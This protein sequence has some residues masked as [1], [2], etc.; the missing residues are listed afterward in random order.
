V[1]TVVLAEDE[2]LLR[3]GLRM[4]LERDDGI[5]VVAEAADGEAALA[6]VA[7]HHPDVLLIDLR[8][9]GLGGI[10]AIRLLR[11]DTAMGSTRALVLT[12][13][14]DDT[15]VLDALR[16]GADGYLL[17]DLD[18][19]ELRRSVRAVAAGD[20]VVS[21]AV[22][23][24]VLR[25]IAGTRSPQSRLLDTFTTRETDV[26]AAVGRGLSNA[27]IAVELHLSPATVRTYVSR[28]LSR[29]GARDRAQLV[30]LAY[31]S[32]LMDRTGT[33]NTRGMPR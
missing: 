17:K 11:R 6:S 32:G 31:E 24:T 33:H 9:P 25:T 2:P 21:P 13:F 29:S 5:T 10:E 26:L 16:A 28:M 12:T 3:S 19:E 27:E 1:I 4:L 20:R 7:R 15:D 23:S 22:L 30:V 18:P 8:M 14:D